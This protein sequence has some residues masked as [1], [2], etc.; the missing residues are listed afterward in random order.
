MILNLNIDQENFGIEIKPE[1][2]KELTSIIEKM[3]EEYD[4][5]VQMGRYW[6]DK[7]SK[8]QRCQVAANNAVNS[9]HRENK[10]M[11]Y[12][13]STYIVYTFPEVISVMVDTSAEMHEIDIQL[14]G[15]A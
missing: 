14:K 2:I 12:I 7:P 15:E 4:E 11:L 8:E 5:G 3:D 1:L 9:I 10:R 6:V 13:M